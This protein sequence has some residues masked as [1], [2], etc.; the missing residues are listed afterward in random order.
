MVRDRS[1]GR[2]RR[3]GHV[4]PV[5]LGFRATDA[6]AV[7]EV[8]GVTNV[9]GRGRAEDVGVE[10][11]DHVGLIEAVMDVGR[12]SKGQLGSG[13]AVLARRR[14]VLVPLRLRHA[15]EELANLRP[16][17]RRPNS[18]GQKAQPGSAVRL[19]LGHLTADRLNETAPGAD[20]APIHHGLRPVGVVHRQDRALTEQVRRA[21]AR[22]VI[23]VAFELGRTP[24]VAFGQQ[25][26]ADAAERHRRGK[27]QRLARDD[28]FRLT[29]VGDDELVGLS[30]AGGGAGQR[31]R[32]AHQLQE[33]APPDG[34]EPLGG[35]RR[36]L[37]VQELAEFVG[38]G[39]LVEAPPV[40][41]P[42]GTREPRPYGGEI[43]CLV[44]AHRW[45]VE[46]EVND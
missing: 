10:R 33:S 40:L 20:L 30:R 16:E 26:R 22:G 37:A 6:A 45:H 41:L 17:R 19:Q 27:E 38:L 2:R 39:Q 43:D 15:G 44:S 25:A 28:V 29:N 36:K 23:G 32:G 21:D 12:R 24:H 1:G 4:Q 35:L 46:H 18:L 11:D 34:I 14:V 13:V 5:H 31:D 7:G 42:G 3:L 8:A 9:A